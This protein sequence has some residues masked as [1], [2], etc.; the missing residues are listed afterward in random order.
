MAKD[1]SVDRERRMAERKSLYKESYNQLAQMEEQRRPKDSLNAEIARLL[2]PEL[3]PWGDLDNTRAGEKGNIEVYSAA[4]QSGVEIMADGLQGHLASK[5]MTWFNYEM[6]DEELNDIKKIRDWL[7]HRAKVTYRLYAGSNY[8]SSLNPCLMNGITFGDAPSWMEK[9][10]DESGISTRNFYPRNIWISRDA[11]GAVIRFV[12]GNYEMTVIEAVGQL[13]KENLSQAL[14]TDFEQGS[15]LTKYKFSHFTLAQDDPI[16]K[17]RPGEDIPDRPWVSYYCQNGVP[18]NEQKIIIPPDTGGGYWTQPFSHWRQREI[19]GMPYGWGQGCSAIISIYGVNESARQLMTA[20]NLAIDPAMFVPNKLKGRVDIQP[21]GR[22]YGTPDQ[23]PEILYDGGKYAFGAD[24]HD[25]LRE[26]V[27]DWFETPFFTQLRN[28]VREMTAFEISKRI[29]ETGILL[30]P[31]I[32]RFET[33]K[34][35]QDHNRVFDLADQ[36]ELAEPPPPILFQK[37]E[38]L[39]RRF[40]GRKDLGRINVVYNGRL[41]QAMRMARLN[42]Q[43]DT[44]ITVVGALAA[45]QQQLGAIHTVW[46]R[47]DIDALGLEIGRGVDLPEKVINSDEKVAR[48]R[49]DREQA[50][51]EQKRLEMAA[52]MV[53]A[54]PKLQ[55]ETA[56]NSPLAAIEAQEANA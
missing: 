32:G 19:I 26:E 8:Y 15:L 29:E 7:Q 36:M 55:G 1:T 13:G 6:A 47:Y 34:L 27:A 11:T 18:D 38:E 24:M 52:A 54:V 12:Y 56:E 42:L 50:I 44:L 45:Q 20:G 48:I 2:R 25:R 37:L 51:A 10:R 43:A 30:E 4:P 40:P 31:K 14:Q 21:R 53:E 16:L 35:D 17:N 22:T 23:K 28:A 39:S 46:D 3:P 33:D 5:A 49:T 9:N 41:V